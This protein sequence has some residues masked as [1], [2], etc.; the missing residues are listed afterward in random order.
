MSSIN[1]FKPNLLYFTNNM[2]E[3]ACHVV[4]SAKQVGLT[5]ALGIQMRS[6]RLK[7]SAE[8]VSCAMS[9][10][11]W[12]LRGISSIPGELTLTDSLL[13]FTAENTGTAWDWQLKRLEHAS[14]SAGFMNALQRGR[15]AVLFSESLADVRVRSPWYYF[16]GGVV[17]EIRQQKYRLSFG[18]PVGSSAE[19]DELQTITTMRRAGKQWLRALS[20]E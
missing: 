4:G 20:V 17:L 19:E 9:S 1:S 16:S 11:A 8:P 15:R 13:S 12:L 7:K 18:Q 14:G 6:P 3:K 5:R 2:A 10:K